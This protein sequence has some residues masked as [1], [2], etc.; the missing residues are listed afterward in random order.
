L[1]AYGVNNFKVS[2]LCAGDHGLGCGVSGGPLIISISSVNE[3]VQVDIASVGAGLDAETG[4]RTRAN[5]P[6]GYTRVSFFVEWID[7][8]ICQ[9]SASKP[10][11]CQTEAKT[12]G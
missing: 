8:Q 7:A 5:S 11:K 2:L 6:K 4:F 10:S 3:D 9:H 1:K 12:V